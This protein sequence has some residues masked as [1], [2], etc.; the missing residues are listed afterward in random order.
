MAMRNMRRS[1]GSGMGNR[2]ARAPIASLPVGKVKPG[3]IRIIPLGGVEEIGKNMTAIEIGDD[4][5]VIDI[6]LAFPDDSAPGVDYI[7]PDASYIEQNK[8]RVR[9]VIVTHAHLDHIGGIP[10]V[11]PRIGNPPL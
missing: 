3:D 1:S 4:I 6:G 2:G 11:M 7:I 9:G 10:Y 5:I 8:D